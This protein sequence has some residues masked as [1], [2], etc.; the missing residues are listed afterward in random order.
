MLS[1][2]IGSPYELTV[3]TRDGRVAEIPWD[4]SG[5]DEAAIEQ[6]ESA[7]REPKIEVIRKLAVAMG[8][9]IGD[10]VMDDH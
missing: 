5:L 9:P 4:R 8:R 10:L 7:A 1:T 6:L 3:R 2:E